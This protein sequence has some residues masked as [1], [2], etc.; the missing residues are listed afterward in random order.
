M[1][2]CKPGG[3][4]AEAHLD[5]ATVPPT[6]C[7][8][9]VPAASSRGVPPRREESGL[10]DERHR[11]GAE[12]AA[13]T[14]ALQASAWETLSVNRID[15]EL[16]ARSNASLA[17]VHRQDL[18]ALGGMLARRGIDLEQLLAEAARFNVAVPSWG[19]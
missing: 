14:A 16:I 19:F 17:Q 10:Q 9:A 8:A 11:D 6:P 7:S 15:P 12:L 2:S 5:S 4:S 18:E 13:E 1:P 3:S